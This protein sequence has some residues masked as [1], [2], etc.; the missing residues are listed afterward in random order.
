MF[1][2]MKQRSDTQSGPQQPASDPC[3]QTGQLGVH[4]I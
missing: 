1:H 4:E 3:E 2:L